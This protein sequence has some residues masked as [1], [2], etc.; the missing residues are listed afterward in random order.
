MEH[1]TEKIEKGERWVF[2]RRRGVSHIFEYTE[3]GA[4]EVPEEM[5]KSYFRA[6]L[7]GGEEDDGRSS[8]QGILVSP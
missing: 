8:G 2:L 7:G 1:I 4:E 3:V 5:K 6:L